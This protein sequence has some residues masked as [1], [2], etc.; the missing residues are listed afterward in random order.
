MERPQDRLMVHG[1]GVVCGGISCESPSN[2]DVL[3][4]PTIERT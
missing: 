3:V 2:R 1:S 4:R